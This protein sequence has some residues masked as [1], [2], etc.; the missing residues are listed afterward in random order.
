MTD[1]L[2][3]AIDRLAELAKKG[4]EKG[5]HIDRIV[6][7]LTDNMSVEM[8]AAIMQEHKTMDKCWAYISGQARKKIKGSSGYL[9]DQ[10][11]YDMAVAYFMRDDAKEERKK[12]E[13]EKKQAE[14]LEQRRKENEARMQKEKEEK[15]AAQAKK[16]EKQ[17]QKDAQ[18]SLFEQ[19]GTQ[20]G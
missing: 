4:K 15:E 7:H 10:D 9:P 5:E 3:A 6:G 11:V 12:A 13:D 2:Q 20:I 19:G 1:I 8:A 16:A 18:L 14:E 17:A